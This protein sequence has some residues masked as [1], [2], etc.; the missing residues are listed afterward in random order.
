M[1]GMAI[2]SIAADAKI[3]VTAPWTLAT[4]CA[5]SDARD[6]IGRV[7]AGAILAH[8][9][10]PYSRRRAANGGRYQGLDL[11][12]SPNSSN[13]ATGWGAAVVIGNRVSHRLARYRAI[14]MYGP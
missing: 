13:F 6:R 5:P 7:Q 14:G 8:D 10:R 2:A 4:P 1:F 11:P 12:C 9:D 3:G